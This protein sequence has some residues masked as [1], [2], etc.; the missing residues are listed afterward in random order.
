MSTGRIAAVIIGVPTTAALAAIGAV[1]ATGLHHR[2]GATRAETYVPLPGDELLPD[3]VVQNDRARTVAAPTSAVW[4]W[5]AQLGQNKAGFYSFQFLENLAGCHIDGAHTIHPEWQN[6]QPGDILPL[7]PEVSVR[8]AAVE[9]GHA[10]VLTSEGLAAPKDVGFTVTWALTV[11]PATTSTGEPATRMHFRERYAARKPAVRF[12][13]EGMS[14]VSAL[15][16][17]PMMARIGKLA[18]GE[19]SRELL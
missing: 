11:S 16:S 8:V 2:L 13:L 5:I 19:S 9:P 3:A 15:M 12:A 4:P 6:P 17:W 14:L 10:L 7:H 1:C 18:T